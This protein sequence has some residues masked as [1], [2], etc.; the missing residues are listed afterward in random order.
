MNHHIQINPRICN[1]K[2]VISGARISVTAILDQMVA[3]GS[4]EMI[5][6]LFC[7]VS[8][9]LFLA[10]CA[11]TTE[12]RQ[13][14][15]FT[16]IDTA[17]RNCTPAEIEIRDNA[18]HTWTAFCNNVKFYCTDMPSYSCVHGSMKYY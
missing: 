10:G 12:S 5:K 11:T 13:R 8:L 3:A 4:I 15:S 14:L 18:K 6:R 7:I 2:P 17:R 1:G 9:S 16:L